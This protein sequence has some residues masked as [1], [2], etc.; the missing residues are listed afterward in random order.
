M[1]MLT[2]MTCY[3]GDIMLVFAIILYIHNF[4]IYF[5]TVN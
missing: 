5:V 3:W 4:I 2:Y 1:W